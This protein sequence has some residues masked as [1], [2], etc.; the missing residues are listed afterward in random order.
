MPRVKRNKAKST[1]PPSLRDRI[2]DAL[3]NE[4]W[5][6]RTAQ[7]IANEL[8][9]SVEAVSSIINSDSAV[10]QSVIRDKNGSPL[11]TTKKRKSRWSDYISAFRALNSEKWRAE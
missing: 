1:L 8:N 11:Y 10:R 7:G 5:E 2:I 6:Y 9:T 3:E 4:K